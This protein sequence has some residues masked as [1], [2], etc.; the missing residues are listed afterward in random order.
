MA[1]QNGY[2]RHHSE[3]PYATAISARKWFF[4]SQLAYKTVMTL[5]KSSICS[6]YFHLFDSS[7]RSF[8]LTLYTVQFFIVSSGF[9]FI[10]GAIFQ[11]QPIAAFWDPS[12]PHSCFKSVPWWLSYAIIQITT[13]FILLLLP[14]SQVWSMSLTTNQKVGVCFL[15]SSGLA[16]TA[17][18]IIRLTTLSASA[19]NPDPTYGPIPATLWAEIEANTAIIAST[20]PLLQTPFILYFKA[21]KKTISSYYTNFNSSLGTQKDKTHLPRRF[22]DSYSAHH[23]VEISARRPRCEEGLFDGLNGVHMLRQL[24][25]SSERAWSECAVS[26]RNYEAD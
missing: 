9:V 7:T 13:D 16:A 8:R 18:S 25:V 22:T 1:V 23:A 11:C 24:E 4:G 6:S 17:T 5:S 14:L 26:F 12:M 10:V 21:A 3:L 2:G 20:L 19:N 15:F